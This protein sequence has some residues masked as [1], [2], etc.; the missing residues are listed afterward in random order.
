MLPQYDVGGGRT[1]RFAA[2]AILEVI[3]GRVLD[4]E[5]VFSRDDIAAVFRQ[6]DLMNGLIADVP[7]PTAAASPW[8]EAQLQLARAAE[9]LGLDPGITRCCGCHAA[10][11]RWP[12]RSAATTAR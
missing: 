5:P 2:L 10:A 4:S 6:D 1:A 7:S 11:S 3:G 12:C 8:E 9:I